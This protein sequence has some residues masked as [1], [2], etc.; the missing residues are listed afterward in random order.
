MTCTLPKLARRGRV[1]RHGE[2]HQTTREAKGKGSRVLYFNHDTQDLFHERDNLELKVV[3]YI[4]YRNEKFI[5]EISDTRIQL[6]L[7]YSYQ[8]INDNLIIGYFSPSKE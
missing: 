7:V 6:G 3:N 2:L 4:L 8:R 1:A 5:R